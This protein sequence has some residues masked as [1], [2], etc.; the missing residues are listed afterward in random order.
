MH[1]TL[2]RPTTT[3]Y[4]TAVEHHFDRV[5]LQSAIPLHG[6]AAH[7]HHHDACVPRRPCTHVQAAKP[8]NEG[9]GDSTDAANI[10]ARA[11]NHMT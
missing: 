3:I 11:A 4:A 9:R 8:Q 6:S 1:A 5:N 10:A 7:A 2:R